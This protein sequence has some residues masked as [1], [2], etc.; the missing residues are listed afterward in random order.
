[1]TNSYLIEAYFWRSQKDEEIRYM[2]RFE[3][4][5]FETIIIQNQKQKQRTKN[6]ILENK[7]HFSINHQLVP[8]RKS[9]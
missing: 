7:H 8:I 4:N 1:M 6:E 5:Y 3:E 9:T 2:I